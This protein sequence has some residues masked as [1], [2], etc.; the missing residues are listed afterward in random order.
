M[1]KITR[2]QSPLS[3]FDRDEFI[4]P[5]DTFF[6][7]MLT[8]AFP[9]SEDAFGVKFFGRGSYPK[10]DVMDYKDKIVLE[11]EIPGL[12]KDDIDIQVVDDTLVLKCDKKEEVREEKATY[13]LREL[14]R[15]KSIRSFA[16]GDNINK[17]DI[18][19]EFKN[20]T[21]T[22]TLKKLK[23]AETAPESKKIEIK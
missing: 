3:L 14:K 8:Q 23:P 10:V 1:N 18:L 4:T 15:S 7:R 17:E 11:A 21:L 9:D 19:A 2:Y 20:G 5:F 6:D 22:I 12:V 13:L 16:L